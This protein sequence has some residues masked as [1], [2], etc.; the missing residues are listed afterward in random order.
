[1]SKLREYSLVDVVAGLYQVHQCLHDWLVKSRISPPEHE[2]FITAPTCVTGST[3][4]NPVR[5]TG[6][7]VDDDWNTSSG[8]NHYDWRSRGEFTVPTRESLMEDIVL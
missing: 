8:S 6:C 4:E 1:M 7:R 2:L 3:G 5:N